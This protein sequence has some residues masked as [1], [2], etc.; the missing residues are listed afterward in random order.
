MSPERCWRSAADARVD[1]AAILALN[2]GD[3]K[4]LSPIDDA[5]LGELL[6][7]A[8]HVSLR[9]EGRTAFLIAF[10]QNADYGSPNFVWFKMRFARFVYV[11]RL[12]VAPGARGRGIAKSM[13]EEVFGVA[14]RAGHTLVTC[15]VTAEPPNP[16]S[17]ALHASLGFHE[18]G[19]AIV[20]NGK[21]TV[22]YLSKEL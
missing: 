19:R 4:N 11:D 21:Q 3:E 1:R 6:E 5:A 8:F 20:Y 13:Y 10:D 14:R 7:K 9:D 18:I 2:R 22:R 15:E 16:L 12:V 17:D